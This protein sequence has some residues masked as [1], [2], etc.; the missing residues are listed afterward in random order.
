[1]DSN[2]SRALM[3]GA[4]AKCASARTGRDYARAGAITRDYARAGA[5]A[6]G[7]ARLRAG[8]RS[9][10]ARPPRVFCRTVT[11]PRDKGRPG[12]LPVVPVERMEIPP[13]KMQLRFFGVE[14]PRPQFSLSFLL[15]NCLRMNPGAQRPSASLT[16]DRAARLGTVGVFQS[17]EQDIVLECGDA[18]RL[19]E[20]GDSVNFCLHSL[21]S[22]TIA[23]SL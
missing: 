10:G 15:Q 20:P 18:R 17:V 4:S 9:A 14:Q 23:R 7:Q 16:L 11:M 12:P 6:R 2:F 21:F 19:A 3:T 5:V 22:S 13:P 8:A 1:M